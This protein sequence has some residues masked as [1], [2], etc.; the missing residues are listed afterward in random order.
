M[1]A[2]IPQ[3]DQGDS[4][5][6]TLF[7]ERCRRSR[8]L[9]VEDD[10]ND[11]F[12]TKQE[13]EKFNCTVIVATTG[14]E[15]IQKCR[16]GCFDIAVIDLALPGMSGV[17]TAKQMKTICPNTKIV[18]YSGAADV[19]FIVYPKPFSVQEVREIAQALGCRV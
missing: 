13:F 10:P 2:T 4:D 18:L 1:T 7:M 6:E 9:L 8:I 14:E 19:Q 3:K 12:F 16:T 17:D 15:A 11:V 5:L